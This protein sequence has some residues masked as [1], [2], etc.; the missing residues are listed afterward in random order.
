MD[1]DF[2]INKAIMNIGQLNSGSIFTL[3]DLFVGTE[4][5]PITPGD[6]RELGRRF[7]YAVRKGNIPNVT[8]IGKAQNNSS[9]Y[10]KV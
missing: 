3:K 5:N 1:F 6:R 10:R 2:Y 8:F 7:K 4:W 9:K